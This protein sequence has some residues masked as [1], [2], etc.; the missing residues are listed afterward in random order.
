[1]LGPWQGGQPRASRRASFTRSLGSLS[2]RDLQESLLQD[3]SSSLPD[4]R[5]GGSCGHKAR[6]MGEAGTCPLA[7]AGDPGAFWL[8]GLL[9]PT[10]PQ[11]HPRAAPESEELR[12]DLLISP[13]RNRCSCQGGNRCQPSPAW[14]FPAWG[15]KAGWPG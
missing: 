13:R 8:R 6:E 3:P 5:P 4:L 9:A 14:P 12:E 7:G 10:G 11:L 15:P 1:M 2:T